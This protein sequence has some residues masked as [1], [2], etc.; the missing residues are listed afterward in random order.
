LKPL[1]E[2]DAAASPDP[3]CATD[4]TPEVLVIDANNRPVVVDGYDD[5]GIE[6]SDEDVD[7]I[8]MARNAAPL[9]VRLLLD[10]EWVGRGDPYCIDCGARL[11]GLDAHYQHTY[12]E[13]RHVKTLIQ[14]QPAKTHLPKCRLDEG[15]TLSGYDTP[16]KRDAARKELQR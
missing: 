2:L 15:L 11:Y 7:L 5:C 12:P 3:W 8:V 13:G 9:M 16:E 10:V 14:E 1:L 6:T 4:I